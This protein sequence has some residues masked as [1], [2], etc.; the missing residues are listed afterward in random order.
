MKPILVRQ[1]SD[2]EG[3]IIEKTEPQVV[4]KVISKETSDTLRSLL[5]GVVSDGT[6]R[7][8]YV[9]GYR[10]AGKTGTSETVETDSEGRYIAS[11]ACF[12]PADDPVVAL[13]V[14]LDHPQVYPHTGGALALRLQ[15]N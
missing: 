5:Q 4:R 14:V 6:G 9:S 3:N 8:A 7:N 10:I 2:S 1:I 15:E 11:F 13:I 12:A